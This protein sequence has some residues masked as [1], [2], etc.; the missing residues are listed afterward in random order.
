MTASP[1]G[2]YADRDEEGALHAVQLLNLPVR[3][4]VDVRDRHDTLMR[5]LALLAL[6]PQ[7]GRPQPPGLVE[8]T[9][10]LGVRYGSAQPR[11]DQAVDDAAAAGVAALDVTYEVPASVVE[12]ARRLEALMA[13]ADEYCRSEQLLTLPRSPL[14]VRFATWYLE[15]FRRQVAGEP[16]RPWD[17]PL[18]P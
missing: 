11:P 6:S 4:L 3:L 13:E 14:Q 9:H 18:D 8:L 17:G 1:L 16:A 7:E 12:A 10:V 15:E 5:E 2:R